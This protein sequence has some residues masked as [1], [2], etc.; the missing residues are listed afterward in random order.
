MNLNKSQWTIKADGYGSPMPPSVFAKPTPTPTKTPTPKKTPKPKKLYVGNGGMPEYTPVGSGASA[1]V[2]G[3][4][5][6]GG[7][8]VGRK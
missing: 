7:G 6:G 8:A 4:L 3:A 1:W 5:G 2:G